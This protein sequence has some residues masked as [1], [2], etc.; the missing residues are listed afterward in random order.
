MP[1]RTREQLVGSARGALVEGEQVIEYGPCWAA[2]L[3]RRVPLL[4]LARRQ[5]LMLLTNRRLLVFNRRRGHGLRPTDLVIGKRYEA[6]TMRQIR[7]ARPLLQVIVQLPTEARMGFEFRP[8][9]R[10]LRAP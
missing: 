6:F 5:Y 3:R 2:P 10:R 7:R 4:L 9:H 1:R 8:R